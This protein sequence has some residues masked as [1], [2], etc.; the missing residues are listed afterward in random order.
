MLEL[1]MPPGLT[2][3]EAAHVY[4]LDGVTVPSVT[5]ALQLI[6][7]FAGVPLDVLE[8]AREFGQH[9]H[10]TVEL[11]ARG[12][13]DEESL[14]PALAEYLAGWRLFLHQRK[15]RVLA[16]ELRVCSRK[17]RYAGTLD[18]LVEIAG[19]TVLI[20]VKSGAVPL[21][22]VGPQT[23]AYL[24]ALHECWP[25][26][27]RA[28]LSL[29]ALPRAC[30]QLKPNSFQLVPLRD[31]RDWNVFLSALNIHQWRTA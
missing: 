31:P 23:A 16:S 27:F 12:E 4:R 13:L 21:L 18:A 25:S 26:M 3:D 14:D 2:F 8:R 9:V 1:P 7:S 19:R 30:V 20:D 11:D 22:T 5:Q 29:R 6:D 17:L 15:A 28:A 10:R 24:H